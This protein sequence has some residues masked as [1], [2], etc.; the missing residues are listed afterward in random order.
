MR[1]I[2][3][4]REEYL[5]PDPEA[6]TPLTGVLLSI[7]VLLMVLLFPEHPDF[8]FAKQF[9][10][11]PI[12]L[13][14]LIVLLVFFKERRGQWLR[15]G[16]VI[17]LS[18][19]LL[20]R[21][22]DIGSYFAFNRRFSPLLELHLLADGW[23]LAST[24]IGPTQAAIISLI[25]LLALLALALLL[26]RCLDTIARVTG[27][28][29]KKL[30]F[31]SLAATIIGTAGLASEKKFNYNGPLEANILPEFSSRI[32][33]ITKS[34]ND[35]RQFATDLKSDS[36]LD[37][38]QPQFAAL[39]GKDIMVLFVESYGRGYID[40][41]RFKHQSAARLLAVERTIIDAGLSIRSGWLTSPIRGGRS[42]LAHSTFQSGLKIDN[43]A[44]YDRLVTSQRKS[45]SQLFQQAGWHSVGIMPAIQL[46]WPEGAWYGYTDLRTSSDLGYAGERFGYVTMPDQYTLHYFENHIRHKS[47]KPVMATMALLSTHAPWTPL[48]RKLDWDDIGNGSIYDGS[49]RFGERISW[50][51]RSKVQD[52]YAQSFDYTLD[53][54]GEYAARYADDAVIIIVGDH[55]P[56]P[57][58]NG[59]G[60]SA[61]VPIHIISRD[62]AL[63]D[64]LPAS[65]W[66]PGM[67]PETNLQSLPMQA[68]RKLLSTLFE[69]ADAPN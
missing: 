18:L 49:H 55:Q 67:L 13:P 6:K 66:H 39:A 25:A 65:Q 68:M 56:A 4:K 38:A 15:L 33:G 5:A 37:V 34:I 35:Q 32:K 11:L 61:D 63:L 45:V 9:S 24:S 64:R 54:L 21:M 36:V 62:A 30:L 27:N 7:L 47:D 22:A 23:N 12:E 51:Y 2:R 58:I 60:D 8:Q 3:N 29:R 53:I 50:K 48:P 41:E 69:P 46:A 16:L 14:V 17:A 57:I 42:W 19:L 59:W 10:R 28:F 20:L 40:A 1:Q 52:M 44:R 43:Q 26:Y 31:A